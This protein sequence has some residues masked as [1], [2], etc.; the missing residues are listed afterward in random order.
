[1]D[2]TN[3]CGIVSA[4]AIQDVWF[5]YPMS[6][7]HSSLL[8]KEKCVDTLDEDLPALSDLQYRLKMHFDFPIHFILEVVSGAWYGYAPVKRKF[9]FKSTLDSFSKVPGYGF[10]IPFAGRHSH[11]VTSSDS[12]QK[13][14]V[15]FFTDS[16]SSMIAQKSIKS[17]NGI[18]T[19]TYVLSTLP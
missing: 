16:N 9:G 14:V 8:Y 19:V 15:K 11:F 18:R 17:Y 3:L 7:T 12:L 5:V 13:S 10:I 2:F 4:T 1:M 6:P